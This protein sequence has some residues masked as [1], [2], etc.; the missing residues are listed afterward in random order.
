MFCAVGLSLLAAT[1]VSFA[2]Q[3]ETVRVR[4][5]I[6]AVDGPMLTVK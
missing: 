1:S 4:G 5:T 3:P 2:Q 6:E